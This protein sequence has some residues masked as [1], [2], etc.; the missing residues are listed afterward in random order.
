MRMALLG[1]GHVGRRFAEHLLGPY[2]VALKA[3]GVTPVVSG[4]A[5]SRH[6]MAVDPEG[7]PLRRC[8]EA[9]R[10]GRDLGVFHRGEAI[11]ST[12]EFIA[13]VKADV[14]LE[15]TPLDPRRG[16]PATA[17]VK[18][19]LRRG[20]HVITANKGPV[21]FARGSLLRLAARHG[22]SF[23]HEGAVMDGVPVFNLFERCL[24]GT[25]IL[26]FRGTLNSTTS[27]VLSRMGEGA[28]LPEAVREAQAL[29][30][31]EA[32]PSNDLEGW[33][34]AVKGCAIAR[35]L[36][37][38]S[39]RPDG[40]S[41]KGVSGLSAARIRKDAR[42]GVRWRLVVRGRRVSGRVAVSV[43]PEAIGPGDPLGGEGADAALFLQTDLVG[44][45]GI[46]ERGGTIDQTAYAL[47]SDLLALVGERS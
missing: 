33:D 34:S 31:A 35:A 17:Y 42:G 3:R 36:M 26:G 18:Q 7:L 47:L 21:A 22:V 39:V 45:I 6:G 23:R 19:G 27:H 46:I 8:L 20:L 38:A 44:E 32:D 13:R 28:S 2:A 37:G 30:I 15:L 10:K 29:G 25:R 9:V 5:T 11:P 4:I 24:P 41:R 16:E 14:L 40:V 43:A 1:F 12:R